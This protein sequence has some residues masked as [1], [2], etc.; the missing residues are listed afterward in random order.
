M[1]RK[2]FFTTLKDVIIKFWYV[3]PILYALF[4][5]ALILM[6]NMNSLPAVIENSVG[7]LLLITLITLPVSWIVLLVNK[8]WWRCIAS[9]VASVVIAV[10]S[11]GALFFAIL[12]AMFAPD[13]STFGKDHPIPAD[14][15]YNLPLQRYHWDDSLAASVYVDPDS[16]VV[17]TLNADSYLQIWNG[18]QGGIYNYDFYY[19]PLPAGEIYLK[20]FEV[21]E[22]I[23]LSDY[24]LKKASMVKINGTSTFS[25]LVDKQEFTIYEGVFHDYYAARIEVWF[26]DA[27][28]GDEK[29]LLEKVY[30]V[31]GWMR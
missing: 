26:K 25:K 4:A 19:G 18:S 12:A 22:D 30:R 21:T 23:P 15:E 2:S 6:I 7:I 14:L 11:G 10:L 27:K 29:K 1:E 8:R 20:C 31:E 16:V 5:F 13:T 3:F 17:D 9:F 24:R 28:T